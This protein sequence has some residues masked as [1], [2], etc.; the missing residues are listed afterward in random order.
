MLELLERW[1]ALLQMQR[2]CL[3]A[4]AVTARKTV[5][6]V[7]MT[8]AMFL[9]V[10]LLTVKSLSVNQLISVW[11]RQKW[12]ECEGSRLSWQFSHSNALFSLP[13]ICSSAKPCTSCTEAAFGYQTS[14]YKELVNTLW[15]HVSVLSLAADATMRHVKGNLLMLIRLARSTFQ[16]M[17]PGRAM[18]ASDAP[19]VA[20]GQYHGWHRCLWEALVSCVLSCMTWRAIDQ[21]AVCLR[22]RQTFLYRHPT[23]C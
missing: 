20:F 22:V 17:Y 4:Q 8:L 5:Q 21:M 13:D 18:A 10:F 3:S 14:T 12:R 11:V 2:F 9:L 16:R 7:W 15:C 1:P 23:Q 19:G 6:A